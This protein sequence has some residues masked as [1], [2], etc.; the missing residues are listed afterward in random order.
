[1]VRIWVFHTYDGSSILPSCTK[2]LTGRL[3]MDKTLGV[4]SLRKW[5]V[6]ILPCQPTGFCLS[7]SRRPRIRVACYKK[8]DLYRVRS[9]EA[10]HPAFNRTVEISKF[11]AP[12]NQCAGGEIGKRT[13]LKI[14]RLTACGFEARPAHQS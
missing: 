11:S 5:M 9:S 2:Q 4:R 1:V 7:L 10:E 3:S 6:P 8:S 14:Q 12:T 13:G